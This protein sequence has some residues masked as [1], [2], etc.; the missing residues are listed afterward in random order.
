MRVLQDVHLSAEARNAFAQLQLVRQLCFL[1]ERIEVAIE[2]HA[3]FTFQ[4]IHCCV[5]DKG[6]L[7]KSIWKLLLVRKALVGCFLMYLFLQVILHYT[8]HVLYYIG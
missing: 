4:L 2:I 6:L 8:L 7:L 3:L 5:L 1:L